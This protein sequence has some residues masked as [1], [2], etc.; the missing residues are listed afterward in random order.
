M[1]DSLLEDI[2]KS[3]NL[4]GLHSLL[5]KEKKLMTEE[6]VFAVVK[7]ISK[8]YQ[9]QFTNNPQKIEKDSYSKLFGLLSSVIGCN[10]FSTYL[11]KKSN[12][13]FFRSHKS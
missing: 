10:Y 1:K 2:N 13:L 11:D 6:H 4:T 3:K 5:Q 7:F 8:T 12:F 9:Q